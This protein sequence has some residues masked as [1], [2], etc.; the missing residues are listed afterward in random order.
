MSQDLPGGRLPLV[1]LSCPALLPYTLDRL[2]LSGEASPLERAWR[3][4][5]GVGTG[6]GSVD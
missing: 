6:N 5:A 1:S 4:A 3:L 2:S